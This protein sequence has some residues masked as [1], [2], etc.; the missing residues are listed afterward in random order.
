MAPQLSINVKFYNF[1]Y[2][3]LN[4]F[5]TKHINIRYSPRVKAGCT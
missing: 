3:K 4:T 2:N 1:G 5:Y